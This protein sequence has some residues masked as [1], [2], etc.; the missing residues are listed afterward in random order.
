MTSTTASLSRSGRVVGIW[1]VCLYLNPVEQPQI[2]RSAQ[3]D[4]KLGDASRGEH[5]TNHG[6]F[7]VAGLASAIRK[8]RSGKQSATFAA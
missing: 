3:D 5:D 6:E 7:E 8:L 1:E 4:N 2:L